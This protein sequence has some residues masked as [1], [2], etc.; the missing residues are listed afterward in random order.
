MDP[1]PENPCQEVESTHRKDEAVSID[2]GP[3]PCESA[4]LFC[5]LWL[6]VTDDNS[7]TLFGFRWFRTSHLLNP[8][9]MEDKIDQIDHKIYQA[10]LK[11]GTAPTGV[12]RL[13]PKHG[14][15]DDSAPGTE[16]MDEELISQLR[17]L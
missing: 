8:H 13:G 2:P 6:T 1:V 5:K 3:N 12:D 10:G 15:L 4:E 7:L 14:K 9:F 11:L 16:V 17:S